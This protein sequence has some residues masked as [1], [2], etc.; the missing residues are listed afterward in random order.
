MAPSVIARVVW[1]DDDG[2]GTTGTILNNALH[3]AHNDKID[4]MFS[5]AG[6]YATLELGGKLRLNG[7]GMEVAGQAAPS[8]S[9]AGE[10]KFY[11]DSSRKLWLQSQ[12]TYPYAPFVTLDKAPQPAVDV[13]N[14]TTETALWSALLRAGALGT[15][16]T[17]LFTLTGYI[18]LSGT[19]ITCTI[20]CYVGDTTVVA[21]APLVTTSPTRGAFCVRM[22]VTNNNS[23]SAQRCVTVIECVADNANIGDGNF[24]SGPSRVQTAAHS[25]CAVNPAVDQAVAITAQWSVAQSTAHVSRW[26]GALQIIA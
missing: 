13:T 10:G 4:A 19:S 23:A 14:T 6:A 21:T 26:G 8:V 9:A 15:T 7:A 5:G 2:S 20:R 1:T 16:G 11:F 17:L 22:Y 12:N 24:D 18:D 3:Q 25:T